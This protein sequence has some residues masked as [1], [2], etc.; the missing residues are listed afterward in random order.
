VFLRQP[1]PEELNYWVAM[2]KIT[3][4]TSSF[5]VLPLAL[6]APIA[7]AILVPAVSTQHSGSSPNQIAPKSP[8]AESKF[9]LDTTDP[10]RDTAFYS[11]LGFSVVAFHQ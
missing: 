3:S 4:T 1:E 11:K 10:S 2:G 8:Y 6:L 5:A 9:E 7:L